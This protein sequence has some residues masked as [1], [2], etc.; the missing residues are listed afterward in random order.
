MSKEPSRMCQK[1]RIFH[2]FSMKN[3]DEKE[4]ETGVYTAHENSLSQILNCKTNSR[5]NTVAEGGDNENLSNFFKKLMKKFSK[6]I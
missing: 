5:E 2:S 4:K 1:S 6:F 3:L